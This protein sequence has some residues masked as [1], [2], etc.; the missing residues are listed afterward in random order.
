MNP[1]QVQG[2]EDGSRNPAFETV[3]QIANALHLEAL[4]ELLGP[5]P[6]ESIRAATSTLQD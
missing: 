2:I 1:K 6:L 3:V 5:T 4:D